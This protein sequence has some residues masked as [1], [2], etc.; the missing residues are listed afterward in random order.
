LT[1]GAPAGLTLEPLASYSLEDARVPSFPAR[2]TLARQ[3]FPAQT[4]SGV[5]RALG[6]VLL[7]VEEGAVTLSQEGQLQRLAAGDSAL[8][9]RD[10]FFGIINYA[11]AP[12]KLLRLAIA[13][14]SSPDLPV[15]V[16]PAQIVTII[17][18]PEPLPT[19]SPPA[20]T[21]LFQTVVPWRPV[22]PLRLFVARAAWDEAPTE[23]SLLRH[24][25]WVGLVVVEGSLR[26]DDAVTLPSGG[27]RLA[28][29]RAPYRASAGDDAPTALIFGLIPEDQALWLPSEDASSASPLS[30]DVPDIICGE[31]P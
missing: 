1:N 29:P 25:G 17:R 16:P 2:M 22:D 18:V 3:Q 20:R 8:V 27:C 6:P 14:L 13:L 15:S 4:W 19:A 24:P 10:Q 28:P 5:W 21:W 12:A 26:V 31:G 9:Q 7:V 30:N 11:A 23:P